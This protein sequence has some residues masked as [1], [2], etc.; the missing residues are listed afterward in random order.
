[1]NFEKIIL[2]ALILL[3]TLFTYGQGSKLYSISGVTIDLT[4]KQPIE[5]A[6]IAIYKLPDTV[7]VTGI[8]TNS[9]GEFILNKLTSGKYIIKSSFVGYQTNSK[10]VDIINASVNLSEP[11]YLTTSSLS[12]NEV[13]VTASRNEKQITIEKTK[14]NVAQNISSV[15]GNIT[16]F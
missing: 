2:T 7:L 12:L 13:Q 16:D 4:S 10:K 14:I 9:K 15:S 6:S 3:T 11:I 8:I 1:M 5:F